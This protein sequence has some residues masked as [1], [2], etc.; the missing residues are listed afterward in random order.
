LLFV[1]NERPFCFAKQIKGKKTLKKLRTP[2]QILLLLLVANILA[3]SLQLG[4]LKPYQIS[5]YYWI[6][7][8]TS[9]Y[10][11]SV[12]I[13]FVLLLGLVGLFNNMYCALMVALISIGALDISQY[14][15][16][17]LIQEPIFPWDLKQLNNISEILN[18]VRNIV[19]PILVISLF[20]IMLAML[21]GTFW[22]PRKK[23]RLPSRISYI[24]AAVFVLYGC[25]HLQN[26][27]FASSLIKMGAVDD[28]WES[29]RKLFGERLYAGISGQH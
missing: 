11:L 9:L 21:V 19:S 25:T 8:H 7:Q 17:K 29:E 20:V 12:G 4:S 15:K 5:V 13:L 24:L 23:I 10:F 16:L 28:H 14:Y 2:Y 3:A 26:H 18:V 6:T 27:V 1:Q 22:L